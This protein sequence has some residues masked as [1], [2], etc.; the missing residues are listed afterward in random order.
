[1]LT[2]RYC[3]RY[4]L[5]SR[6]ALKM[7]TVNTHISAEIGKPKQ[8][9]GNG[10]KY[11]ARLALSNFYPAVTMKNIQRKALLSRLETYL[12]VRTFGSCSE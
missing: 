2:S 8:P 4:H 10:V 11:M 9:F 7:A 1:M 5:H 6:F 3:S 12:S